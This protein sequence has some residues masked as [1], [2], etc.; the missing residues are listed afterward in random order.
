MLQDASSYTYSV[1]KPQS[2]KLYEMD[3]LGRTYQVYYLPYGTHHDV[4]EKTPGGNLMCLTSSMETHYEDVIEELDRETG[5][6]VNR[7]KLSDVFLNNIF[8]YKLDWAHIN[9]VSWQP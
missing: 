2:G 3:Y 4:T 5:R 9:T 1:S 8:T 7:L 6:T